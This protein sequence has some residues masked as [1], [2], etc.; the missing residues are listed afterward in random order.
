MPIPERK[1]STAVVAIPLPP[2]TFHHSEYITFPDVGPAKRKEEM[3]N[4]SRKRRHEELERDDGQPSR[5][6]DQKQKSD[7]SLRNLQD[8]IRD[9]FEAEDQLQPDTSGATSSDASKYFVLTDA[10]GHDDVPTLAPWVHSKLEPSLQKVI[11]LGR[12]AEIPVEHLSRL[13]KLCEGALSLSEATELTIEASWSEDDVECWC[14]SVGVAETGLR[15]ARTL[16]RIM[17]GGREEK[18]LYSEEVLQSILNVLKYVVDSCI[19]PVVEARST[20]SSSK[21]FVTASSQQKPLSKLLHQAGRVM[22]SLAELLVKV[23]VAESAITTVEFLVARLVFVENAHSEKDSAVG[24]QKFEALRRNATDVLARIFARYEDQRECIIGEILTSLEKLPQTRQNARQFKLI[25]GK[26]IQLVSALIMQLVQ[27]SGAPL[28]ERNSGTGRAVSRTRDAAS[29]FEADESGND[30]DNDEGPSKLATHS[31]D[32]TDAAFE[33]HP[34]AAVQQLVA[35]AQPLFDSASRI[36]DYIIKFFVQRAL[37]STKTGDQPYRNLLDIFTEDLLNVLGSTDWPAA[38]LLLRC[39]LLR[40]IGIADSASSTAP[41]KNMALELLGMMGSAI[42]DVAAYVRQLAKA[43]DHSDSELS[44]A[45]V[46]LSEDYFD[47]R[48]QGKDLFMWEGPYRATLQYLQARDLDD[49]QLRSARGYYL[50]QWAI[51]FSTEFRSSNAGNEGEHEP[52]NTGSGRVAFLLRNMMSD[53]RWL[54]AD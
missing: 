16:L 15:S 36:A 20:G 44:G 43:M 38:E 9:V 52:S 50:T 24:I 33:Q 7:D 22:R 10:A 12:F 13:Q 4:M 23:E 53:Y 8:L 49:S 41:A 46:Q 31:V 11:S 54:E 30:E 27:T 25:D 45:L 5:N 34:G 37:K 35:V 6:Y 29:D 26:N 39:L 18:Q 28:N 47:G 48:L 51:G 32:D 1:L 14:K 17:I 21:I 40:T 2:P 19:V 42:S 3:G